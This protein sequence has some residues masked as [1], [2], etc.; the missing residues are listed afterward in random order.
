MRLKKHNAPP[1]DTEAFEFENKSTSKLEIAFDSADTMELTITRSFLDVISMLGT[2]F[3]DAVKQQLSKRDI[4]AALYV[5]H[6][7]LDKTVILDL[8]DSEFSPDDPS[9]SNPSEMV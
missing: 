2:A 3:S 8:T 1:T 9:V 6:N 5:V 7:Q 4:P